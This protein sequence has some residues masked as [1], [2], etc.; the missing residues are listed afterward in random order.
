MSLEKN[1]SGQFNEVKENEDL[2]MRVP[3]CMG[4]YPTE[5]SCRNKF[6]QCFTPRTV[7][8]VEEDEKLSTAVLNYHEA[9]WKA[10]AA[11][12]GTKDAT[13]CMQK[14]KRVLRPDLKKGR[15]SIRE[16]VLLVAILSEGFFH[17]WVEISKRIA[18]RS[19][20]QVRRR[21]EE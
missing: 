16:D 3:S 13:Q 18:G 11:E 15:W 4:E 7:W 20:K 14:W 12:V 6:K 17:S 21:E 5:D 8:R 9:N 2:A 10:V 19:S 1:G